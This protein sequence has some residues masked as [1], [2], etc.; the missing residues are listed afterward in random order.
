M[1]GTNTK[2]EIIKILYK[3]I[4]VSVAS[5]TKS[6]EPQNRKA[7]YRTPNLFFCCDKAV[8]V[9]VTSFFTLVIHILT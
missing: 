8:N 3:S 2:I 9:T 6:T 1:H 5:S 4:S 7:T